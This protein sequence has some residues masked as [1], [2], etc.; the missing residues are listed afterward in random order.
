MR[1]LRSAYRINASIQHVFDCHRDLDFICRTAN[2]SKGRR[3][4]KAVV[5]GD[6]LHFVRRDSVL[7]A[8]EIE[9]ISPSFLKL[10]FYPVSGELSRL[11]TFE[12]NCEFREENDLTRVT[13]DWVSNKNPGLVLKG[14]IKL[15]AKV[16]DFQSK[17]HEKL[18]IEAIERCA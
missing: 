16:I 14:L 8:R 13:V 6:E 11:G 9:S 10:G 5:K 7:V 4:V 2:T 3:G 15:Y 12:A 17:K 1:V 18:L